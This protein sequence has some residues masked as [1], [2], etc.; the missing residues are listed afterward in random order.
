MMT[1]AERRQLAGRYRQFDPPAE[2]CPY[3]PAAVVAVHSEPFVIRTN[4]SAFA[5]Y[6]DDP[7]T[8]AQSRSLLQIAE[9]S[10]LRKRGPPF[11]RLF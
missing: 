9:T 11:Q 2:K 8:L 4:E 5:A 3:T 10:S 6:C 1:L 7:A